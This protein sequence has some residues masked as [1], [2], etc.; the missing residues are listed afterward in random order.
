[1]QGQPAKGQAV[2]KGQ[3]GHRGSSGKS[4]KR[5]LLSHLTPATDVGR[6]N[7]AR[8]RDCK[9]VDATCRGCGKKGHYK[10][11]CLQGKHSAHSLETPQMTLAGAGGQ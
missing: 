4:H 5:P 1:M 6:G 7:I 3:G 10:K 11:V 2:T 8:H 9:A